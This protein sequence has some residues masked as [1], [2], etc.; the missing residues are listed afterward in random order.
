MEY[1]EW[2][3]Q[4][5]YFH[6]VVEPAQ[7]LLMSSSV[8]LW[9]ESVRYIGLTTQALS[10]GR[11]VSEVIFKKFSL[12]PIYYTVVLSLFFLKLISTTSVHPE[13]CCLL[14]ISF[15]LSFFPLEGKL[16]F[17]HVYNTQKIHYLWVWTAW[18]L[19]Y[20]T[21]ALHFLIY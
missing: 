14:C 1:P 6:P 13:V 11:K 3:L 2:F 21:H 20:H 10:F 8:L 12:Y 9:S 4:P 5:L 7:W 18:T 19:S 17:S 15:T 16:V